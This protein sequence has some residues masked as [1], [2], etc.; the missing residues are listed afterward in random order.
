MPGKSV[1]RRRLIRCRVVRDH[2]VGAGL[3][4]RAGE[5]VYGSGHAA[6][7]DDGPRVVLDDPH[8]TFIPPRPT[9]PKRKVTGIVVGSFR[10]PGGE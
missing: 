3:L 9:P 1:D 5:A 8:P 2:R 7:A 10:L 6:V 4:H